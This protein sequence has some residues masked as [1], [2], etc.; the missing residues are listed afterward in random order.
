[1]PK[2]NRNH[3]QVKYNRWKAEYTVYFDG[4]ELPSLPREGV[5]DIY[6]GEKY[7]V[8]VKLDVR[9]Y[10]H[11][12]HRAWK[13]VARTN[14]RDYFVPVL[15]SGTCNGKSWVCQPFV[16][17]TEPYTDDDI[18]WRAYAWRIREIGERYGL[19]DL[20]E[21]NWGLD[22]RGEVVIFDYGLGY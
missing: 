22:E 18:D 8:I 3:T 9:N 13:H 14:D 12:D 5:R 19:G 7:G 11:D 20:H 2:L 16:K 6:G 1:M 4:E 15:E 21:G 17:F 10:S